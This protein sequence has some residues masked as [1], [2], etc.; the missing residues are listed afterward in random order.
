MMDLGAKLRASGIDAGGDP[1]ETFAALHAAIGEEATVL[2]RY[3]LEGQARGVPVEEIEIEE[4]MLLAHEVLRVRGY[5]VLGPPSAAKVEVVDYDPAWAGRFHWWRGRLRGLLGET[6]VAIDHLGSTAV[7]GLAAK[8]TV[9]IL[10]SVPDVD[11]EA[12]FVSPIES[13]GVLL[14]SRDEV[15]RYFRPVA[16]HPRTVQIHVADGASEW[17]REHLLFRDY[18]RAHPRVAEAYG[19]LKRQI[20][21]EHPHDR[22]A[23]TDMKGAF[24]RGALADAAEWAARQ[25]WAPA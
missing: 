5:Q 19:E 22:V 12:A 9:D 13:T 1:G 23:Y 25:G 14:R 17:R 7:P 21:V 8:P 11:D 20:A 4:R 10:V 24:I 18:L 15:H 3:E 6:A 2:D 16:P